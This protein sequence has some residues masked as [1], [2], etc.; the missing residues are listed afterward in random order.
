MTI[1]EKKK[2][3]VVFSDAILF[4]EGWDGFLFYSSGSVFSISSRM[5]EAS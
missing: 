4:L 2:D 1:P 5:R 3:D